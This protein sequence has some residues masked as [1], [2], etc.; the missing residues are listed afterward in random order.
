MYS[1]T[2]TLLPQ[3]IFITNLEQTSF[4][5]VSTLLFFLHF[6]IIEI[7]SEIQRK[8]ILGVHNFM[9]RQ[10][11]FLLSL[12]TSSHE[13]EV[14]SNRFEILNRFEKL[15]PLHGDFTAARVLACLRACVLTC[16]ACLRTCVLTCLA[17]LRAWCT[18]LTCFL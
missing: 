6:Q 16:L 14:N 18:L 10:K 2:K 1:L 11:F 7:F 17:C 13:T 3:N 8:Y 12:R 5:L 4:F 9:K 15:Y